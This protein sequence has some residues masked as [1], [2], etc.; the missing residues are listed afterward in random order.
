MVITSFDG[1]KSA[2]VCKAIDEYHCI[3]Q[4]F[5]ATHICELAERCQRGGTTYAPENPRPKD[6]VDTY[7]IFQIEHT[8]DCPYGYGSFEKA[9][10]FLNAS[11]YKRAYAGML[12]PN[13]SLGTLYEIHNY[14]NRPFGQ[15]MR[16][17][18]TSDIIVTHIEGKSTAFYVNDAATFK[19]IPGMAE[20]LK[21]VPNMPNP[22]Q[23]AYRGHEE[24]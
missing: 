15:R 24:R 16:S 12:A 5:T 10:T 13:V 3:L 6:I 14:D 11:D 19:E 18:S 8:R 17:L 21:S 2:H 9:K 23:R 20:R 4:G 22:Q 1:R 7:E